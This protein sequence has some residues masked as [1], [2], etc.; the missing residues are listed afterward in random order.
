MSN[1]NLR[2]MINNY[3][4][5][6]V[7]YVKHQHEKKVNT[8]LRESELDS[9]LPLVSKINQWR[10]RKKRV[11][12]P[13]FPSYVFLKLKSKKDLYNA[14]RI[15]SVFMCLRFGKDYAVVTDEEILKIKQILSLESL[16]EIHVAP[17]ESQVGDKVRINYGPLKGLKCEI[18]KINNK[19]RLVVRIDSLKQNIIA[20]I[21]LNFIDP[22]D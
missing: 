15:R 5:W 22:I 8:L 10:D 16:S 14:L 11:Q 12:L 4:G 6:H 2:I 18:F 13:L 20:T 9:F 21:P 1:P 17:I 7:L 3:S 19:N